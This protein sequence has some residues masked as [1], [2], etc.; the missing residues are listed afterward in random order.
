MSTSSMVVGSSTRDVPSG[1]ESESTRSREGGGA[2]LPFLLGG[3]RPSP[4]TRLWLFSIPGAKLPSILMVSGNRWPQDRGTGQ[5]RLDTWPVEK[6]SS[7]L[8]IGFGD[9]GCEGQL[10]CLGDASHEPIPIGLVGCSRD[11]GTLPLQGGSAAAVDH[12]R[13]HE[14][15]SGMSMVVV[16]AVERA[17][18][19]ACRPNGVSSSAACQRSLAAP[20]ARCTPG[21][22]PRGAIPRAERR[23]EPEGRRT[24]LCG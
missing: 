3:A 13:R 20:V 2:C 17:P 14:A 5:R 15:D 21:L 10:G 1:S 9:P 19:G 23:P 8:A 4:F 22:I 16:V 7:L 24:G 12:S 11:A 18:R 6:V